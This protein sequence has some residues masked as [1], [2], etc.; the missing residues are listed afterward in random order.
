MGS[1]R[2]ILNLEELGQRILPSLSPVNPVMVTEWANRNAMGADHSQ[3]ALAGNGSG[4]YTASHLWA[5]ID[6]PVAPHGYAT[7]MH[8]IVGDIGVHYDFTGTA[9]LARLGHVTVTGSALSL[10]NILT[11][12]ASGT[13]V[14]TNARGS[15]TVELTGPSQPGFAPLPTQFTYTVVSGTGAY[16]RLQDHGSLT[17]LLTPQAVT[18]LPGA[19]PAGFQGTFTLTIAGGSKPPKIQSGID[20]AALIDRGLPT[21]Y[22]GE[23]TSMPLAGA[24]ISIEPA[25]G[26]AEVARVTADA[27]GLFT[28]ALPPGQ[29]LLVPQPPTPGSPYP[30]AGAQTVVVKAGQYAQVTVMYDS[31]IRYAVAGQPSA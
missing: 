22:P 25:G 8:V 7:P 17:L 18:P 26:G 1:R 24:V 19:L 23:P 29:Y 4:T 30:R 21:I 15:V 11:G 27:N 31:G 10:G 20:G 6:P 9:D 3:H 12:H 2:T 28:I 5:A 14:F 16:Q 13:L